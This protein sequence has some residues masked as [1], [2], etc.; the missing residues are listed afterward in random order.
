LSGAW[1]TDIRHFLD[2]AGQVPPGLPAVPRYMCAITR[3]ASPAPP[4]EITPLDVHCR[5]RPGQKP[6]PGSI[7]ACVALVSDEISW[8]CPCCGDHGVIYN[9][10]ATILDLRTSKPSEPQSAEQRPA[11]FSPAAA[12]AWQKIP[13]AIRVRLLNNFWCSHCLGGTSV[14]LRSGDVSRGDLILRGHCTKCGGEIARVVE[15]VAG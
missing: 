2:D 7:H 4:G 3:A 8:F 14:D 12:R 9:W 11:G 6:C 15:E 13:P 1:V 5:R 10:G